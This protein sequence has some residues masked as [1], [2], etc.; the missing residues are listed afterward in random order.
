VLPISNGRGT[1]S[2]LDMQAV[3]SGRYPIFRRIYHYLPALP[4]KGSLLETFMIF[5]MS[6]EGQAL[7]REQGFY[8]LTAEDLSQNSRFL[9]NIR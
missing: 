8:P 9:E 6:A 1:V 5:E 3:M 2:P 7:I 4:A